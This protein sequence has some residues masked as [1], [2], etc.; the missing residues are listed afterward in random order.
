MDSGLTECETF[1]ESTQYID[2]YVELAMSDD[3]N[4]EAGNNTDRE[5][6]QHRL[7]LDQFGC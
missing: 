5:A 4:D 1:V 6:G 2:T 7:H 3:A